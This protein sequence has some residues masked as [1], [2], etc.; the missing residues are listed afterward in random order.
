MTAALTP[1][2][3]LAYLGELSVDVRAAAV[4]GP[5]CALLAG[6]ASLGGRA[7]AAPAAPGVHR[8]PGPDGTLLVARAPAGAA[9]AVLAG[10]RAL[11][12]LL[13]GDLARI[14]AALVVPD[15]PS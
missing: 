13:E 9:I 15:R 5:D 7:G 11:L 1:Q 2:L 8:V 14:A 4:L 10:D 6:D 3:A 12:P